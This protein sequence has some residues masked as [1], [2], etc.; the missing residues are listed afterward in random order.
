MTMNFFACFPITNTYECIGLGETCTVSAALQMFGL[1]NA[2]YPFDWIISPYK[3]LCNVLEQDFH[4][5]LDPY[6]LSIRADN[7]GIINKYE[8]VF[9][10]DFPTIYYSGDLENEDT[11]G[12]N[13]LHPDWI[14]FL[15]EIQKKYAR[16]IQ[17]LRDICMSDNKVYFIR[18]RGITSQ[19]Q[20][21]VLRNI[22]KTAYPNLDFV[23]VVIGSDPSF[24]T[25]WE[26]HNIKNY[27]LHDTTVWNDVAQWKNIFIDLGLYNSKELEA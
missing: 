13:D 2:A 4:D 19:H 24:S 10:H 3:S 17:R 20:A 1:R 23:L 7:H 27:Y 26:E 22:L 21:C 25:Q 15:P 5:F 11:V 8:L 18:H 12:E 16:R 9:V 6:Y 14:N